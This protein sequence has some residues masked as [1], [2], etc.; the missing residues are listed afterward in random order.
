MF[1][2]TIA[3]VMI[4]AAMM[5]LTVTADAAKSDKWIVYW[6]VCGT[7]IETTRIA[8]HPYSDLMS[9]DPNALILA[10]PDR[11]PGDASRCIQEVEA[12]NLSP[13]VKIF[14]QAGGTNIWG[15]EKFRPLNATITFPANS[16]RQDPGDKLYRIPEDNNNKF[17]NVKESAKIARYV[18][19]KGERDWTPREIFPFNVNDLSTQM[20][21]PECLK[22]FLRLN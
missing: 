8:L 6:Y 14:M 9:D 15:H 7:D 5:C 4:L 20:G 2:R 22:N 16:V 13:E 12:A 1:K 10:D 3:A 21:S 19:G 18:Y 11:S 17:L